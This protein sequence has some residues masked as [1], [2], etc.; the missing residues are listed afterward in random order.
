M[1]R[2]TPLQILIDLG[3]GLLTALTGV[4]YV[5]LAGIAAIVFFG[6]L[7]ALLAVLF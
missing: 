6:F 4:V 3:T 1:R 7:Y 2:D 5:M